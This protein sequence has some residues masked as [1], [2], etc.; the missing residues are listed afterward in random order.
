MQI[1]LKLVGLPRTNLADTLLRRPLFELQKIKSRNEERWGVGKGSLVFENRKDKI[2]KRLQKSSSPKKEVANIKATEVGWQ[3]IFLSLYIESNGQEWLPAFDDDIATDLLGSPTSS[4]SGSRKRKAINLFFKRFDSL[5]ALP[6]LA[7]R[8][9]SSFINNLSDSRNSSVV[10][11]S[12]RNTLFQPDGHVKVAKNAHKSEASNALLERYAI[13]KDCVFSIRIR[14][15]YLLE[16]LQRCSFGDEPNVLHEIEKDRECPAVDALPLGAAALRILVSR[17]ESEGR[18]QWPEKWREWLVKLGCDPRMG[19][20]TAEG[21]K[22]WG[23]AT[24]SQLNLAVQGIIGQTLKFFFRF[25]DG[26]VSA[27]QWEERRRFLE[28]CFDSG[29]IIDARLA[30]N[31]SCMQRLPVKMRDKWTTA[32]LNSTTE[33]TCIIALKCKDDVYLL[34]GTHNFALRA[35]HRTFPLRGFWERARQH[36]SDAELRINEQS[37]P[38]Y[39][40]HLGDWVANFLNQLGGQFHVEWKRHSR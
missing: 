26:T 38:V 3:S 14:Q 1:D 34:E 31:Y 12:E 36:Y 10:W 23:W 8:L 17:V 30:L 21:S 33:N 15:V 40:R 2:R 20:T 24:N 13:P 9:R 6:Y 37:C 5:P 18:R 16:V 22:W 29:K 32:N 7:S 27:H 4:L 25:L 19:R 39:V 28:A 35:F 11:S